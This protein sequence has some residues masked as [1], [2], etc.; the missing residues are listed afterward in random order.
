MKER[1]NDTIVSPIHCFGYAYEDV[2]YERGL[3]MCLSLLEKSDLM[4]VYGPWKES[5]GCNGEVL[6]AEMNM[7]PY[8]I[9]EG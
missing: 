7:I 4:L 5:R 1:P 2:S 6:F 8:E 9:V 3:E